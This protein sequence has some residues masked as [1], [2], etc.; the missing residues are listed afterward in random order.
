M[1]ANT[2]IA[3]RCEC[4]KIAPIFGQ[5]CKKYTFFGVPQNSSDWFVCAMRWKQLKIAVPV[6]DLPLHPLL[7]CSSAAPPPAELLLNLQNLGQIPFSGRQPPA[8]CHPFPG[9]RYPCWE[10]SNSMVPSLHPQSCTHSFTGLSRPPAQFSSHAKMHFYLVIQS[11][12]ARF[13]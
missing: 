10:G 8:G 13:K 2:A 6:H 3:V 7:Y 4:I 11:T 9:S 5:I 12:R 1:T